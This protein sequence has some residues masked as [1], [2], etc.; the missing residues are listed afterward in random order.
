M[1]SCIPLWNGRKNTVLDKEVSQILKVVYTVLQLSSEQDKRV[2]MGEKVFLE[3][4]CQKLIYSPIIFVC[5]K[6]SQNKPN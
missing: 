3:L 5:R 6:E 2:M 4:D 1:G